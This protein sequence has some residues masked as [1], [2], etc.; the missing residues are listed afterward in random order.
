MAAWP[1]VAND[2]DRRIGSVPEGALTPELLPQPL[3][4]A[5]FEELPQ[6]EEG[7]AGVGVGAGVG[8]VLLQP[9]LF[10]VE[11]LL[12]QPEEDLG[13]EVELLQ[14]ELLGVEELLQPELREDRP[15]LEKEELFLARAVPAARSTR[16]STSARTRQGP[17]RMSFA[18]F[19]DR[20]IS[21]P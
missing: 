5:G 7:G 15:P 10:G 14:P 1:E 16:T 18:S 20:G 12:L 2:D 9:E 13:V 8:A 21:I 11:G 19:P 4:A 6:P 17:R 3:G